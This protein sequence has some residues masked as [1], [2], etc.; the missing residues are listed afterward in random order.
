MRSIR[1]LLMAVVVLSI[2]AA[3]SSASVFISVN[4]A[5]PVIPVYVQPPCPAAGYLWTPGYWAYGP[6][7]YYWVPGVWVRPPVMGVLWTPGYW[8]FGGGAYLW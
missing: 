7:G 5:P 1:V 3:M 4:F 6:G 8:R 2:S